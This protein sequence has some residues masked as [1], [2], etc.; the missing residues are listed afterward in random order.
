[1]LPISENTIRSSFVNAS[2]KEVSD[3]TLPTDLETLDWESRDFLGW[4]DPRT[5]R[6]AYVVVPTLEG[7][8]VG[9]LFRQAE[10]APRARAQC[11]WC[12]DVTLPN[13]VVFSAA[14]RS[15]KA[16]RNGNTVGTLVC[17][18][19]QC[20]RNVRRPVPPAYEGY[21]VEAARV[22]RIEDLQLRVVSFAAGL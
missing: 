9:I 16:G 17:Q 14:K 12:Q 15:G 19:F 1:M 21:D 5:A 20:S 10:A 7:D 18:D 8:L 3:L 11:S 13:D 22:R 4:R 2:R 6:R